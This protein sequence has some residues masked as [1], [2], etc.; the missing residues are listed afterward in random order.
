MHKGKLTK[1][2]NKKPKDQ[3]S[4]KTYRTTGPTRDAF[5]K[6]QFAKQSD[7]PNTLLIS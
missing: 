4:G 5:T 3:T 6:I 2:K 7:Q 1:T